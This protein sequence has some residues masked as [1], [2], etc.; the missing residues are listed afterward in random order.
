VTNTTTAV[1]RH[2]SRVYGR[3]GHVLSDTSVGSTAR[4]AAKKLTVVWRR[5]G[6][7]RLPVVLS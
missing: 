4:I 2:T 1:S 3:N 6:I 5:T 7:R